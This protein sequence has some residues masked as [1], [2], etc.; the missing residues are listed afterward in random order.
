M[1]IHQLKRKSP[2]KRSSGVGRGGK[3][4]K[5]SGRGHKGQKARA[6]AKLRPQER[7]IIKKL[8]KRRGYR[9]P[10]FKEKPQPVNLGTLE[11]S[12]E[13]GETVSPATL[14]AK[15]IIRRHGGSLPR[16][17]ILSY[18]NIEKSLN[19]EQCSFSKKALEKLKKAGST[20]Q[21]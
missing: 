20:V 9:E 17:K 7:D 16:V 12:Y 1:Q 6:G 10:N 5:T 14:L 19:F 3:R 11:E 15:K 2:L 18:G 21:Q 8:P 13:V 4:G